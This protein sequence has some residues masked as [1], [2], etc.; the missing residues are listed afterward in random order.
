MLASAVSCQNL[1]KATLL[2][3]GEKGK[4]INHSFGWLKLSSNALRVV[5]G[6]YL[7]LWMY[8]SRSD[9]NEKQLKA[10]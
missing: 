2:V 3:R 1:S 9:P 8:C 10:F 4:D 5:S 7:L 6:S